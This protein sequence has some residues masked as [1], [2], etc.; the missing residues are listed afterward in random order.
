M[1]IEEIK[2][3]LEK[4]FNSVQ[5]HRLDIILQHALYLKIKFILMLFLF[6]MLNIYRRKNAAVL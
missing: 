5:E 4:G 2:S 6:I 3:A 1:V